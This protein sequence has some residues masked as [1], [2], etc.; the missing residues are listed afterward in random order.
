MIEN[1]AKTM[2]DTTKLIYPEP[3]KI[4]ADESESFENWGFADT[5]FAINHKGNVTI[6]GNRYELSGQELPRLLPWISGVLGIE[7]D[8]RD[9]HQSAYPVNIPS[10]LEASEFSS[11]IKKFL[12]EDQISRDDEIRLRHGHGQT[13][14]EVFAIKHFGLKRI[15]DLVVRKTNS[16]WR[17]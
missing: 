3:L 8:P 15:P 13:Q 6:E 17:N 12:N 2:K 10:P 1:S 16:R 11:A 9:V 7:I 14:E 4:T 5:R